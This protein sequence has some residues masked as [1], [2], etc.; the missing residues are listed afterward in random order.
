MLHGDA[1]Q[2]N[3]V[4]SAKGPFFIDPAV[5]YGHPEVDLAIVDFFA[6]VADDLFD[7]YRD[8]APLD[9]GFAQRRNLWRIPYWLAMDCQAELATALRH[10]V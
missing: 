4:T 10:L 2:N 5:Y 9:E 6:P 1:H 7:G 3:I 8:I